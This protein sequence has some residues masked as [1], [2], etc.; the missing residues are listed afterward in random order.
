MTVRKRGKYCS[1]EFWVDNE[2]YS[3]TFNGKDGRPIVTDKREAR[4]SEAIELRKV[5][6]GTYHS[7]H[8][9]EELKDFSTFVDKVYLPFANEN[10]SGYGHDVYRT[11]VLKEFFGGKRFDEITMMSVVKYVNDGLDSTTVHVEAVVNG[12]KVYRKRSPTTVNKELTLL[13]SI[14]R[15]AKRE[16][17]AIN[18]PCEDLPRSVRKKIPARYRRNRFLAWEEEKKLFGSGLV[19]RREHLRPLVQLAIWTGMRRG[20]L[21]SLKSE[22]VN[23]GKAPLTFRIKGERIVLEPNWLL[24]E[25][26]KNGKPRSIPLSR[27]V[28]HILE[29]LCSD[30]TSDG[31]VFGNPMTGSHVKDI[32]HGFRGACDEAGIEDLT[33]HDL[34]HTWSTRAA[35]CGVTETVRR[36]IL[37]HSSSTMTGDYTHSTHESQMA[38][39]EVVS[40]YESRILDK[41]STKKRINELVAAN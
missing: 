19:G 28:R 27:S 40:S 23:L 37:G 29:T 39:M 18:N 1:Y 11:D 3:G 30:V 8:D 22:H 24:M 33:F 36:D 6:D 15:M 26:T 21:L 17:V 13:S 14:F 34:R 5:L 7:E 9:R 41:S 16:K 31:Y 4:I 20:E 10:H 38:A 12:K 2:R 32:K 25:K 35:E